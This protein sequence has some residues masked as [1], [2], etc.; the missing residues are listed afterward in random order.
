M[1]E[2]SLYQQALEAYEQLNQH[3]QLELA[4]TTV[5][6]EKTCQH[7]NVIDDKGVF[8]CVDC[9]EEVQQE[10]T[11]WQVY[12]QNENRRSAKDPNRIQIRK[13][14]ER[15]IFKDVETLSLSES[16]VSQGNRIYNEVTKG[17]IFR[18]DSRRAIVFA[19]IFH[20]FKILGIPQSHEN[21]MRAFRL[22][23]RAGLRGLK[24]V[25][26]YAPK[27]SEVRTTQIT[28]KFLIEEIMSQFSANKQHIQEVFDIYEEIKNTSSKINRSRPQSTASGLVFYWIQLRSKNIT[29]KEF[30]KKVGLSEMTISKISK[31]IAEIR[32]G[33]LN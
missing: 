20:A 5:N 31:E 14:E 22:K 25:N 17:K 7:N 18:G 11:E 1:S 24:Y 28:P 10:L 15:N 13:V 33:K 23:R 4:Q 16:V 26:I 29:L 12:L 32:K 30:A 9:G 27:N 21:L 8:V 2:F 6:E 19:C 3:K